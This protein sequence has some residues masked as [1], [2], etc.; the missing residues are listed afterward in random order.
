MLTF[1]KIA[2]IPSAGL[3]AGLLVFGAGDL[4]ADET[5]ADGI[6][7]RVARVVSPEMRKIETRLV[8]LA[9]ELHDLPQLRATPLAERYGFRSATLY[10][11]EKPQWVQLDLGRQQKID[12]IV[13]VPTHIPKFGKKGKGYGFPLRFRIE[14]AGNPEMEGAVTVVDRTA[15]DVKNPGRYPMVFRIDPV[16]GRYVRFVSTRHVPVEDG[17]K[18]GFMWALEELMV[19]SGNNVLSGWMGPR[20]EKLP[21]AS[22]HLDFYPHWALARFADGQSS[23]GLPVSTEQ[24]PS[25]GYLSA[26]TDLPDSEKW[27]V[28]DFG[29]E[30]P[31]DEIRLVAVESEE[32]EVA[33]GRGYPMETV[34]ELSR[35]PTFF[36]EGW[37]QEGG[38]GYLLGFPGGCAEVV[39]PS[40]YR[41]R[42]LRILS[43]KP[44]RHRKGQHAFALAE[45]QAYSGGENVAL[46]KAV[47][48]S[49]VTDK[50]DATGWAPEFVVDGFSSRHQL[51]EYPEYLDLIERR[52]E[53][54]R[55]QVSLIL[56]RDRKV[57]V[58]GQVL[59]YGGGTIGVVALLGWAWMLVRQRTVKRRAVVQLRDQ[60]A[61]DLHDDIGCNLGGIV[62][63]SDMGSKSSGEEQAREDFETIRETAEETSQSMKDIVWLIQHG[64][65][66]LRDLVTR[67]RRATETILGDESF[68]LSVEP[69]DYRNRKVSLLFRRH[70][71]FA[72]KEALNN[73]RKHAGVTSVEVNITISDRDL[74]FEVRDNGRGFDPQEIVA[75]G[76]GL[77]NLKR[78]A[79]RLK[80]TYRVESTPGE[81][82]CIT[83]T[84]P[85]NSDLK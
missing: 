56:Q 47:Q 57:R 65:T 80:G 51:I 68:S 15:E 74:S 27:V 75:P 43:K 79:E 17:F 53:L 30:Y 3:V 2:L 38:G 35:D 25:L 37:R 36:E 67:M 39:L 83:F 7:A 34:V 32:P 63:L 45:V 9:A 41:A 13:A 12:R 81:G 48:V 44:W 62:L 8:E 20:R 61:R 1:S 58:T 14:V 46:G 76:N 82:T 84:S 31:I 59:N 72:F 29:R 11:Q 24:S 49:S 21:E 69:A 77:R 71:F 23:L 66:R 52:G 22:G 10:D 50:L 5:R 19:L 85:L 64:N 40:G 18:E 16:E 28:V 55:E 42:Y 4:R 70:V 6:A 54:E 26:S 60:I 73:V 33:G 78:R